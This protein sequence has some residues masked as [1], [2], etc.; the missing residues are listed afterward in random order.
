MEIKRDKRIDG[1]FDFPLPERKVNPTDEDK[2]KLLALLEKYGKSD[3]E[4]K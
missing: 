1:E 3:K 2:A 4:K